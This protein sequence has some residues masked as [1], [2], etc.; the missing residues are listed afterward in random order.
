MSEIIN[1]L[2]AFNFVTKKLLDQDCKSVNEDETCQYRGY[3]EETMLTI[4][5]EAQQRSNHDSDYIDHLVDVMAM[6]P[7]DAKC[8]VGHLISDIHYEPYIEGD[9]LDSSVFE[10]VQ[11]SNPS[12]IIDAGQHSSWHMLSDLQM[13]HD[14]KPVAEWEE[15]FKEMR[16]RFENGYY[17]GKGK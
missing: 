7:T 14:S 16:E 15:W 1:D 5:S 4:I 6:T 11:K 8:A 9:G 17:T 13:I 12:W 10:M 3:T 2:D